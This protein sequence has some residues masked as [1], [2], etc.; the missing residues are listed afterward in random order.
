MTALIIQQN[1]LTTPNYDRWICK[2]KTS[3]PFHR[4]RCRACKSEAPDVV[5][6][7]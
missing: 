3:H 6:L 7:R 5:I 1:I 2:C 4:A